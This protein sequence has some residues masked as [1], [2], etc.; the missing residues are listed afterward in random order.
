MVGIEDVFSYFGG[1]KSSARLAY[2]FK[3]TI[4]ASDLIDTTFL[5]RRGF[6]PVYY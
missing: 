5:N 4:I 3:S 1:L 6:Y 2:V